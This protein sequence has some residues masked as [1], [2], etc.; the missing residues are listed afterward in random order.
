MTKARMIFNGNTLLKQ[1]VIKLEFTIFLERAEIRGLLTS[2]KVG[3]R[4]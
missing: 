4:A 1:T 3:S 2:V